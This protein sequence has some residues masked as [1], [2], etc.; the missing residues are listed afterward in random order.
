MIVA[1]KLLLPYLRRYR[2]ALA[3]AVAAMLG[4][5]VTAVLAP[6]PIQRV[7]DQV[8]KPLGRAG[9]LKVVSATA[10]LPRLLGWATVL[11]VIAGLN[12]GFT[13][14]DLRQT[15]SIAQRAATDLRRSLFAHVQRLSLAFHHDPETRLGDLQLR[16]GGDVQTVQDVVGGSLS[17]LITNG[18]TA[19]SMLALL[20]VVD[21]RIGLVV[22]TSA[23]V[24]FAVVRRYHVRLRQVSRAS[25]KQEGRVSALL[26]EVLSVAKLV[27][28]FG[29]EQQENE[30][31]RAETATGLDY[32]LQATEYQARV[33]PAVTLTTSAVT[34]AVLLL[35][36]LL[37]L[38]Q[39]ITVGQLIL[40]LAYTRGVFAALRQLAKLSAR[41]QRAG[42]AAERVS[43]LFAR[44]PAI[45][46]P[47]QPRRL[48]GGPLEL[49]FEAVTFGYVPGRPA[50]HSLTWQVP[51]GS[52]V[53]LVGPTGAGKST[54]LSLVPRFYDVWSG[55]VRL[56]GTDVRGVAL[57]ELRSLV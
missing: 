14:L 11:L 38:R 31:V 53:A 41:T 19:V 7:V 57:A 42:V 16:L 46:E 23:L 47:R 29:R 48:P 22:L 1:I 12:A 36:G 6:M 8:V 33:Q 54:L 4:E 30:R 5:V 45:A 43:D 32:G 49:A 24:A 50:I 15:A 17:R 39:S 34:A 18:V 3:L 25:R 55:S 52:F 21:W 2:G 10:E 56:G 27:Q 13:Y 28:A 51:A 35:G 44:A 20:L 9:G 40:I 26:S 37:A